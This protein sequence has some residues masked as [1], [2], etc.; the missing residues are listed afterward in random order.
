MLTASIVLLLIMLC[1]SVGT[2]IAFA[3]AA[4]EGQFRNPDEAA[5]SIFDPD[6]P[7]GIPTD[8]NLRSGDDERSI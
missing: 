5:Y 3:W 4:S 1:L 8:P 2:L 7:V 6:E